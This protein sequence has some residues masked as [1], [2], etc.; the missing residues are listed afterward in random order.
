MTCPARPQALRKRV[1]SGWP[2]SIHNLI[3]AGQVLDPHF[4]FVHVEQILGKGDAF[5]RIQGKRRGTQ[6]PD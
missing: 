1:S 6:D 2:M 3:C 5:L 4:G